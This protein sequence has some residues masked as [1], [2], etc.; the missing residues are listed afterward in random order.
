[1]HCIFHVLSEHGEDG[2]AFRMITHDGF[3]SYTDLIKMGHTAMWEHFIEY[4]DHPYDKSLNHHFLGD[5]SRW[6][7]TRIAGLNPVDACTIRL[8]PSTAD[9]AITSASAYYDLPKGRVEVSWTLDAEG[10]I[11]LTYTA[12]EGVK[13]IKQWGV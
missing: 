10:E 9:G 12:P 1:M 3:P 7:M 8:T 5:I 4:D 11:D 2:L 13:V 6:F